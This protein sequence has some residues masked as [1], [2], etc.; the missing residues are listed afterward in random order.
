MLLLNNG[1]LGMVRQ[2]QTLFFDGRYSGTPMLNPDYGFI[3][4]A[5][6]I[7]YL[8]VIKVKDIRPALQ[9]AIDQKGPILIEFVCDPTE[10]ILPMIPAGGG[11]NDMIVTRPQKEKSASKRKK[12]GNKS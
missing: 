12:K 7:P 2:W 8:K 1:Y 5:Y 6:D 4:K 3:A 9:K 11:F 10:V